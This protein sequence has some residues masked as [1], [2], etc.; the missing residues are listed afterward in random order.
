MKTIY[1][2]EN[3]NS[4]GMFR[5]DDI[6]LI[7]RNTDIINRHEDF[8]EPNN[9]GLN[10]RKDGVRWFCAYRSKKQLKRWVKRAELEYLQDIGFNV[11]EIQVQVY[12][13]G[14]FQCLF[15]RDRIISKKIVT[16][17]FIKPCP[18]KKKRKW[19]SL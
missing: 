19:F 10:L 18:T 15:D 4:K 14:R 2:V 6:H 7:E 17:Q 12:Q 11:V 16:N 13:E 8:L 5:N 1:R 3:W 9:D